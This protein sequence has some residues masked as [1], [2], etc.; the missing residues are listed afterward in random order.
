MIHLLALV[1]AIENL[2]VAD[3]TVKYLQKHGIDFTKYAP[4]MKDVSHC[5]S[6]FRTMEEH[7][8]T[9]G[10]L[11]K[12]YSGFLALPPKE[13][14]N[15]SAKFQM[16]H[17]RASGRTFDT[18]DT[19]LPPIA[20]GQIYV[21]EL[22]VGFGIKIPVAF[23]FVYVDRKKHEI[24]FSYL[25]SNKSNGYQLMQFTQEGPKVKITH[26]TCYTARSAF[27]DRILYPPIH[28]ML[29]GD[30]YKQAFK[31]LTEK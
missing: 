17:D 20:V 24:A 19:H 13:A 6:D 7:F 15:G 1:G 8:E 28:S 16:M 26:K 5:P 21:L 10:G 14:W 11:E 12:V 2:K 3:T 29:V 22:S 25:K 30:F 23:E 31:A 18:S 27:R 4:S 9:E